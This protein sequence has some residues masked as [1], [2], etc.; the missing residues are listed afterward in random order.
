MARDAT[1]LNEVVE[2]IYNAALDPGAWGGALKKCCACLGGASLQVYAIDPKSRDCPFQVGHGLS[3]EYM[4]EYVQFFSKQSNRNNF[5]LTHP[6]V[7]VGYDYLMMNEDQMDRDDCTRWRAKFDFR[8][9]IGGPLLRCDNLLYFGALQRSQK[10]GHPNKADIAAF[11]EL[12]GHLTQALRVQIRLK[13]LELRHR[14]AWDA[15]EHAS[16]G[17]IVLDESGCILESNELARRILALADGLVSNGRELRA[18]RPIDHRVLRGLI[19]SAFSGGGNL[20]I[21]RRGQERP[22][23]LIVAPVHDRSDFAVPATARVLI[24]INDPDS[25]LDIPADLLR[26]HYGLTKKQVELTILLA[27]GLNVREC[28]DKL[29]IADKT[30]RRHLATIFARTDVH[31]QADLVRL[32]FSLPA[33]RR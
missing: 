12:R 31:R 8:Y 22:Y 26:S 9:Y 10:Q 7:D 21:A 23:S 4:D 1:A 13:N 2:E 25:N 20:A 15:I 5:H 33:L 18:L 16:L 27:R 28:A 14:S 11:R 6:E 3:K 19:A 29:G 24:L 30:A 32:V 17:V